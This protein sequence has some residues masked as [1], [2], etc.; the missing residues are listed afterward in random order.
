MD[1]KDFPDDL[2]QT[3]AAWNTTYDALAA[4]RPRD[5]TV[6]RRRLLLLSGQLWWHPYWMTVPSLPAA[7]SE[8]RRLV[9]AHGVTPAA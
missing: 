8:L 2:V 9:R 6:L 5:T 1:P 4:P 3:Q 7:R